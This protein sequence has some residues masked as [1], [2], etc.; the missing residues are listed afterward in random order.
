MANLPATNQLLFSAFVQRSVAGYPSIA[1]VSFEKTS[2]KSTAFRA[3]LHA[4]EGITGGITSLGADPANGKEAAIDGHLH[5]VK[6]GTVIATARQCLPYCEP[7]RTIL[8]DTSVLTP[9]GEVILFRAESAGRVFLAG[10]SI[11]ADA[12]NIK[13]NLLEFG[14]EFVLMDGAGARISPANP[15]LSDGIVLCANLAPD[16]AQTQE[17]LQ[18]QINLLQTRPLVDERL[19]EICQ[20]KQPAQFSFALVDQ[21][22]GTHLPYNGE[23]ISQLIETVEQQHQTIRAMY[24]S[25][26]LTDRQAEGLV[27]YA[28]TN[29]ALVKKC[30]LIVEDPTKLMIQPRAI[31]SIQASPLSL[32]VLYPIQLL[33]IA[34]NS[35]TAG[36]GYDRITDF[37]KRL[38]TDCHLP[39]FDVHGGFFFEIPD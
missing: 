10:P 16:I 27:K 15:R 29:P 20:Q 31:A 33:G 26:A 1:F 18:Y 32:S 8:T 4:V 22:Y 17:D 35:S 39:V 12:I 25:G 5:F 30:T 7:T 19:R 11:I 3:F 23:T 36:S 37:L 28:E 13:K 9:L 14:A 2:G 6:P 34:V 24:F 21:N 38:S